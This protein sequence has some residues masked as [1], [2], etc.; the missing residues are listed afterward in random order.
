MME[1]VIYGG[2]KFEIVKDKLDLSYFGAKLKTKI[3]SIEMIKGIDKIQ[4]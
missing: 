3:K 4:C 1:H 2:K